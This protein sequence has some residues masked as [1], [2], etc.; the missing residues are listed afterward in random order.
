VEIQLPQD[1]ESGAAA[2][3]WGRDT[4][5]RIAKAI[6]ATPPT[7]ASNECSLAGQRIVIKCAKLATDQVGVTYNMLP[8]LA[9]VLGAFEREDGAFDLYRL[10]P[11]VYDARERP[12]RSRGRS[13]GRVGKVR[14]KVFETEGQFYKTIRL[15]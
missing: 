12:T 15:D 13:A 10:D 11:Q 4:A 6:G 9:Y 7:G 3:S 1:R 8:R 14:R 2:S 5:K